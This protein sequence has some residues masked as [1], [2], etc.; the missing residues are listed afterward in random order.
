MSTSPA[1][2]DDRLGEVAQS[3]GG[4]K[5]EGLLSA[6]SSVPNFPFGDATIHAVDRNID[7]HAHD[8]MTAERQAAS[9]D[10]HSAR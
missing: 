1:N 6:L 7:D 5:D 8:A 9:H 2:S 10:H 4:R 3:F